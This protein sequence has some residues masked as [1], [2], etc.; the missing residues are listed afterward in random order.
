[1]TRRTSTTQLAELNAGL[2]SQNQ[3]L[4]G[5]MRVAQ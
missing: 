1:M 4:A 2:L 3:Q 5:T